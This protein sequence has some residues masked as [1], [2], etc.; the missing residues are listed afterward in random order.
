MSFMSSCVAV[1][2]PLTA[3]ASILLFMMAHM[4]RSGN[5]TFEVLAVKH[6]WEKEEKA[7]VCRRG[8]LIYLFTSLALWALMLLHA[9]LLRL[10][11]LMPWSRDERCVGE[12]HTR[13]GLLAPE[14]SSGHMNILR[15]GGG[16]GGRGAALRS[17]VRC[18]PLGE[19]ATE[20]SALD[21]GEEGMGPSRHIKKSGL[22]VNGSSP[23]TG[24]DP[25]IFKSTNGVDIAVATAAS[26]RNGRRFPNFSRSL[27]EASDG[28]PTH[29][30]DTASITAAGVSTAWGRARGLHSRA[31]QDVAAE[32]QGT[33]TIHPDIVP[34]GSAVPPLRPSKRQQQQSAQVDWWSRS[35]EPDSVDDSDFLSDVELEGA[36]HRGLR[37]I[38]ASGWGMQRAVATTRHRGRVTDEGGPLQLEA[39]SSGRHGGGASPSAP[40]AAAAGGETQASM[41]TT[42]WPTAP[43]SASR[44]SSSASSPLR[45]RQRGSASAG[46]PPATLRP[47]SKLI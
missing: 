2:A 36:R 4:L 18:G 7:R 34:P 33:V 38:R 26:P 11:M 28:T 23:L 39:N 10:W 6:R 47:K 22:A 20:M 43:I 41:I 45:S 14:A 42:L 9:P 30:R 19:E 35:G 29:P 16:G 25:A 13:Q 32:P 5:W 15:N 3:V 12:P 8:G 44:S 37:Q 31:L 46:P 17:Q 24:D 27:T 21:W 1:C 40:T